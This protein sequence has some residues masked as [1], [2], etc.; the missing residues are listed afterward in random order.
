[1]AVSDPE[2]A[3]ALLVQSE[4]HLANLIN[5]DFKN[6]GIGCGV[7]KPTSPGES[8]QHYWGQNFGAAS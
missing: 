6:V 5:P 3:V 2:Q 7:K 4:S 1:M 8:E